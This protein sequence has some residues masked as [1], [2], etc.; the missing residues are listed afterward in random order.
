MTCT[1]PPEEP[2]PRRPSA[3]SVSRGSSPRAVVP[4]LVVALVVP[5]LA[6]A[7]VH[8]QG[9]TPDPAASE[10]STGTGEAWTFVGGAA[11]GLGAHEFGHVLFGLVFDA[12]PG[13]RRVSLKG[14]PFFAITHRA[15]VSPRQEYVIS[16]AG[17]WMQ[18]A[19]SEWILS[20]EPRLRDTRAPL[21]KGM[22]AFNVTA[23]LAYAT[24]AFARAGPGERDTRSMAL[25]RGMDE[26]W[27][28]ALILAPA[29]LDAIRYFKPE[30][31][32]A[33]WSS[34][35]LKIG[36]VLLVLK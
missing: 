1:P 6:P 35:G 20:S 18:H 24:A 30:A 11:L 13:L 15:D 28:G 17:F 3:P 9:A 26:R 33:A 14:L 23:S 2:T 34:R 22:L 32:W 29:V 7:P 27:V 31:H 8:G 25:S 12:D 21:R 4:A 36:L 10:R 16:S 19:T 5:C